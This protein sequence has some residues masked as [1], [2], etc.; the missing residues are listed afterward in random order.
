MTPDDDR[1]PGSQAVAVLS[2]GFWQRRF[3]SD[4][5]IIGKD[6]L[7]NNYAMTVVGVTPPDF[8]GTDLSDSPDVHVP[9]MMTT[10]FKPLPANRLENRRHRWLTIM[11]R[12]KPGVTLAEAQ[13][14]L[15]VLYHQMLENEAEMLPPSTSAF[16]RQKFLRHQIALQP[17]SQGFGMMQRE[18]R[19]PLVLLMCVT[20]TV[21]LILCANLA[22]LLLA[23]ATARGQEV[24]VRLALGAG[25]RRLIQ[26]WLTESLLLSFL[27]GLAGIIVALWAHKVLLGLM[28]VEFTANLNSPMGWRVFVFLLLVVSVMGLLLG[29]APALRSTNSPVALALH[30][31]SRSVASG[32]GVFSLRGGLIVLQIGLSLPLL[33]GAALFLH[34]LKNLR[35]IDMGFRQENVLLASLNPSLNRYPPE[36]NKMLYRQLLDRVRD[37]P[38]VRAASLTTTSPI[39]GS[40]D[41]LTVKVEGYQPRD[42]EDV[43]PNSAV[44]ST[45]YFRTLG[46]PLVAGRDFS[47]RDS[48][49]APKVA[50]VNETFARYFFGNS[51]PLGKKMGRNDAPGAQPDMEIV[52]VV[53]DAKYLNLREET[54]RHFYTPM[55]Q[56]PRLFDLTLQVRTAGVPSKVIDMVREQVRKIDPHLPIYDVK[57]L[58]SQV[59]D[60]LAGDRILTWLSSLFGVLAT[61]LAA[62][63]LYG[64]VAF[65]VTRRTREI[66]I[67]IA[68]GAQ[69]GDI[70]F[71]V[72]R[73]MGALVSLGVALGLAG[74]FAAS[75]VLGSLLYQ[76]R[77][78]DPPAFAA[79]FALLIASV[80]LA[81]YLPARRAMRVDPV[82]ALRYE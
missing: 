33:V 11:A 82:I 55:A 3:G 62:I 28:P 58:A 38:G 47:E 23:R 6:I 34:S 27:G 40:W 17:G 16:D 71:L 70:L 54:R 49:A 31:E 36:R 66:G 32:G 73:Q 77:P 35:S 56:E 13:G 4:A 12:R 10:I 15:N 18:M 60:S 68:L 81:A 72:L 52:G 79:A 7:L 48:D 43:N 80:A 69:P 46:I 37:L 19:S 65:S 1:T 61:L 39:S 59:D 50:L 63:G 24:A 75:R 30:G 45:D 8:Y 67:R 26:Q 44:V 14:S 25:R 41:E 20:G 57:T 9:M 64:V 74:A 5:S 22:N 51:N 76:V 2:F 21:L 53:R 78:A 42:G 29:L